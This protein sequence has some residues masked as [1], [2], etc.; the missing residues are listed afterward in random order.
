MSKEKE[1]Q[2]PVQKPTSEITRP[3]SEYIQNGDNTPRGIS[4]ITIT[5]KDIK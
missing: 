4:K 2:K 3:T 1:S 5:P